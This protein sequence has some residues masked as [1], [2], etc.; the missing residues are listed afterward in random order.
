MK[1]VITI[2]LITALL[3]AFALPASASELT[4]ADA[5][6][7]LRAAAGMAELTPEQAARLGISG[8]PST[9]DALRILRVAAGL[10]AVAVEAALRLNT[11]VFADLGLTVSQIEAKRGRRTGGDEFVTFERGIGEYQFGDYKGER[12][13]AHIWEIPASRLF[14]NMGSSL[15]ISEINVTGLTFIRETSNEFSDKYIAYFK[16]D[17]S[18]NHAV[19]VYFALNRSGIIGSGDLFSIES[20]YYMVDFEM[21]I[22]DVSVAIW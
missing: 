12:R 22:T 6:T 3:A 10:P 17:D 11:D 2:L 18:V 20:D 5:L 16:Y 1:K 4:T 21:D 8:T 9:A 7:V 13:S 15:H 14:A 19:H